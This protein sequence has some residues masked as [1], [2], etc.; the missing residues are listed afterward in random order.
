VLFYQALRKLRRNADFNH[1]FHAMRQ[2]AKTLFRGDPAK[3]EKFQAIA[4]AFEKVGI[5]D[6]QSNSNKKRPPVSQRA[7]F[8]ILEIVCTF[9]LQ[10]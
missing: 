7:F 10:N 1:S 9:S 4:T 3:V 6:S 5:F 8:I 2:V